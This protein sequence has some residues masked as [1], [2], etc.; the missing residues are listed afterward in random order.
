MKPGRD[1]NGPTI[2][3]LRHARGEAERL[4]SAETVHHQ[5]WRML[6]GHILA[7]LAAKDVL[8][9]DEFQAGQM[10][11]SDWYHSGLAAS[12]VIDPSKEVVDGGKAFG[13]TDR[14]L[15]AMQRWVKAVQAVGLIHC[16][17]LS[18]VVLEEQSLEAYGARRY[19]QKARK[20]A[21]LSAQNALVDALEAL[22]V[23]YG[24]RR[25]RHMRCGHVDGYRPVID[26]GN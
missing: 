25:V 19:R 17:V 14:Q 12:G 8:Q 23:H 20:L 10:F 18:A 13:A 2:E 26:P 4:T 9:G 24:M 11:Y 3:R 7:Q 22:S 1:D 6:D 15:A 21:R 5:A 16:Q